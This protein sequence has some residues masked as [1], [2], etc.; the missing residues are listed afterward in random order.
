MHPVVAPY[1][2]VQIVDG[3]LWGFQLGRRNGHKVMF[4]TW[5]VPALGIALLILFAPLRPSFGAKYKTAHFFGWASFH[6]TTA[7]T[8]L[9]SLSLQARTKTPNGPSPNAA[10]DPSRG[11][12][13]P[14][15]RAIVATPQ[16]PA[17][18]K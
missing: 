4:W 9:P 15:R 14:V 7:S 1:L 2:P 6:K 10:T 12:I 3:L 11:A 8:S 5:I 17:R 13:V 18:K 16:Q